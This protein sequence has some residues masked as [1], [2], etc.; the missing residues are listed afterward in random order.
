MARF[1]A[2]IVVCYEVEIE[3]P[4]KDSAKIYAETMVLE[5]HDIAEVDI[6]IEEIETNG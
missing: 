1:I 6:D 2:D 3:A 4:D 5:G